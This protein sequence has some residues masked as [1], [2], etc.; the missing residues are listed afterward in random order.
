MNALAATFY[1]PVIRSTGVGWVFSI[2]RIGAI[3]SPF[4]GAWI[5]R[6]VAPSALLGMLIVPVVL[7]M[8]GVLMFRDVF[9]R[10]E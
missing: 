5:Q 8:A 2:G 6:L 4:V 3:L 9:R 10:T 7:C 1:P